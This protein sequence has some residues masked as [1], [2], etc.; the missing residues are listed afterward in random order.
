MEPL[1]RS[2][3][4]RDAVTVARDLLG[5]KLVRIC[6]E[7]M[8]AG[9]IVETEAYVAEGDPGNHAAIGLTAR[10]SPMFGPPG[11]AYVYRVH[12]SFC[13]NLVTAEEGRP[14][15]AL[16]RALE[17]TDGLE[18]MRRRRGRDS[19]KELCSGPGKLCQALAIDLALNRAAVMEPP[20]FV[21]GQPE[22]GA[23][24][25]IVVTTRIG[26]RPERGAHLPLRFYLARSPY[27]S[28]R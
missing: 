13:L 8:A 25:E 4:A 27:V 11:H 20:L 16:I 14:E 24:S 21:T 22:A 18:L 1:S 28:R 12:L 2:F 19:L 10:N 6:G 23:A 17:P 9:L 5:R 15:A 26:L 7:G 3:F